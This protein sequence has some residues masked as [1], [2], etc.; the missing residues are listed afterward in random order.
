MEEQDIIIKKLSFTQRP[1]PIPA[2]YRP[3]YKIALI[4]LI[5]RLCCRAETSTLLKLHLF[6]W[7]LTSDKNLSKLREYVTS[8]FSSDFSVWGIEPALNRALQLAIAENI[9]EVVNGKNYKLTEKG[10]KFYKMI[11]ADSELFEKEKSFLNFIGK[12]KITD[13]RINA[14]SNQWTI[15]Y[16]KN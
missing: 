4:V 1:I 8:N 13:S 12:S 7:A 2:D 16:A 11:N 3:M 10:Y 15:N 6:S 14:M 9:C 5:L